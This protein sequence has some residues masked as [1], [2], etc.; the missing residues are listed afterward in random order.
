MHFRLSW[1]KEKNLLKFRLALC[2]IYMESNWGNWHFNFPVFWSNT[3]YSYHLF[4]SLFLSSLF[5]S[6]Q[7]DPANILLDLSIY[8][9]DAIMNG[10]IL[11]F[12]F[13][14][15][16]FCCVD[17]FDVHINLVSFNPTLNSLIHCSS[18]LCRYMKLYH[19]QSSNKNNCFYFFFQFG[20]LLCL[21]YF[22]VLTRI[23]SKW[24]IKMIRMDIVALIQTYG[25]KQFSFLP[26]IMI[27]PVVFSL[28]V[29]SS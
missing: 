20:C 14:Y 19:R 18:F 26:L 11:K 2:R 24:W 1:S 6:F 13:Q 21:S 28:P 8:I 7:T 5:Y 23:C 22:I 25:E 29:V 10:I 17:K 12:Q 27:V 9:F 4:R 15:F 3:V 16:Y